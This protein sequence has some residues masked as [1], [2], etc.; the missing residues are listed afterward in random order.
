MFFAERERE[1]GCGNTKVRLAPKNVLV[2]KVTLHFFLL[3]IRPFNHA[4]IH[5][6]NT[7]VGTQY[8][9]QRTKYKA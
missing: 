9:I 4:N 7:K 1:R 6:E 2:K 5:A 8:T 3:H